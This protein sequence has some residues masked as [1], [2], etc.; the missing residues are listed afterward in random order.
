MPNQREPYTYT[1]QEYFGGKKKNILVGVEVELS[2]LR[3]NGISLHNTMTITGFNA[4]E[5]SD[6]YYRI[7]EAVAAAAS[8]IIRARRRFAE[9]ITPTIATPGSWNTN[10]AKT[11][12]DVIFTA[13]FMATGILTL[14]DEQ[15]QHT[16]ALFT[17]D[18]I[19]EAARAYARIMY[20]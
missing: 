1:T 6:D 10:L 19:D 9:S 12:N 16:F 18:A 14:V 2:K 11:I 8:R 13:N 3:E 20:A 7:I 4:L 17:S 15:F 5:D